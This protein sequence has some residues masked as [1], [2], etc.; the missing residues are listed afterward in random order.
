MR[1]ASKAKR[2]S[3]GW[4]WLRRVSSRLWLA[5]VVH[6]SRDHV[7]ADRLLRMVRQCAG[8]ASQLLI[9]V[10]GWASS[11]NAILRAFP[12]QVK[13]DI[14]AG[15]QQMQVWSQLLI[16][17]VIKTQ[18]KYRLVSVKHSLLRGDEQGLKACLEQSQGGTQINTA[19]LERFNG[20][21]RERL[22][23]LTRKCRHTNWHLEP[24][25]WGMYLIGCTYNL[26]WPHQ[27]LSKAE[28]AGYACTPA[29]A[30]G[31]TTHLW[32]LQELLT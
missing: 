26:C 13:E 24:F 17:Q 15:Q 22:A 1:S 11:P 12:E 20:T 28:H 6:H 2:G 16:G 30:S 18:K 7:L 5:G 29:M 32:S 23:A 3:S 25:Q 27:E 4:V 8:G 14:Q 10:E 19:Y 31:L 9:C 21:I